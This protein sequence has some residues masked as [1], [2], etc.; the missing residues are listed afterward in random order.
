[1]GYPSAKRFLEISDILD[2]LEKRELTRI[3]ELGDQTLNIKEGDLRF[4]KEFFTRHGADGAFEKYK[5]AVGATVYAANIYR[6]AGFCF[7]SL[8]LNEKNESIPIDLNM[9]PNPELSP[10]V[11]QYDLVL[12]FGT[13]EHVSNQLAAFAILHYLCRPNGIIL[14]HIPMVHYSSHAMNIVTAKF[15]E[16]LVDWNEYEIISCRF[17]Q[18]LINSMVT[19][20]HNQKF[21]FIENFSE[22]VE[23]STLAAIGYIV[24]KKPY[25][26]LF[27]PPLDVTTDEVSNQQL[28]LRYIDYFRHPKCFETN[29]DR[30]TRFLHR[31]P[32][33]ARTEPSGYHGRRA[34]LESEI[35]KPFVRERR[36]G[37]HAF[38]ISFAEKSPSHTLPGNTKKRLL[39]ALWIRRHTEDQ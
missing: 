15:I 21:G 3:I 5:N 29:D 16:K 28:L 11:N 34:Y 35:E 14:H 23:N 12:N 13:T 18:H 9:W 36:K 31:L 10:H 39:N 2:S 38:E 25:S 22:F 24:L 33:S 27:V 7:F 37:G 30:L 1:M 6:D 19:F 17:D 32:L 20:H 26:S 8:D 4:L